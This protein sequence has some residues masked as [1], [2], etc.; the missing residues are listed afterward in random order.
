MGEEATRYRYFFSSLK[1][2]LVAAL[3]SKMSRMSESE[4]PAP[5]VYVFVPGCK[6]TVNLRPFKSQTH[7]KYNF[8]YNNLHPLCAYLVNCASFEYSYFSVSMCLIMVYLYMKTCILYHFNMNVDNEHGFCCAKLSL[9]TS[10][11]PHVCNLL[12][13]VI[14][15]YYILENLET[16]ILLKSTLGWVNNAIIIHQGEQPL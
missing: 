6:K 7:Q 10:V 11:F 5:T 2:S 3:A 16:S 8:I 12:T 9:F 14:Y 13:D 4:R 15:Y 1:P